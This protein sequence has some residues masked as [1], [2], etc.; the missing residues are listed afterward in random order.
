MSVLL[1]LSSRA[2]D[3]EGIALRL[4]AMATEWPKLIVADVVA[5][6]RLVQLAV[7]LVVVGVGTQNIA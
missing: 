5:M 2:G 4:F 6:P 1:K 3:C 7:E